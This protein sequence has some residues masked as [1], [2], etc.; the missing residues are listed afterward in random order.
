MSNLI[1]KPFDEQPEEEVNGR[2]HFAF[3]YEFTVEANDFD[4]AFTQ[5]AQHLMLKDWTDVVNDPQQHLMCL[6]EYEDDEEEVPA[7]IRYILDE[8][9][10]PD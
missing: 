1:A 9:D 3:S 6:D 4:D 10:S 2:R 5:A 7:I 8:E